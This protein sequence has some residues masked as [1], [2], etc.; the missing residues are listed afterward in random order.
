MTDRLPGKII[1]TWRLRPPGVDAG[2]PR[3]R[4]PKKTDREHGAQPDQLEETTV[5]QRARWVRP[6][7]RPGY[8]QHQR[9]PSRSRSCGRQTAPGVSFTAPSGVP[10]RPCE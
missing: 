9:F 6:P 3:D 7:G 1:R 5:H 4:T 8:I 2:S 10:A